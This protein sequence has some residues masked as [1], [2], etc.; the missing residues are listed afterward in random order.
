MPKKMRR[1]ALRSA[2]SAKAADEGIVLVDNLA[3]SAPKTR[4]MADTL[5]SLVGDA[6]V[7]VL[8]PERDE[9]VQL[10]LRNLPDARYLRASY[11]N[12]RD[13]LKFDKV[14]MPLGAL[15]VITKWLGKQPRSE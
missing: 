5:Y 6:S 14:I 9:N 4:D 15:E 3:M 10:S 12:V 1:E 8:L 11:L 13:L 2:L 7:L